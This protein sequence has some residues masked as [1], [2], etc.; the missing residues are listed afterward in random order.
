MSLANRVNLLRID[1]S[2]KI[3]DQL[4]WQAFGFHNWTQYFSFIDICV[5]ITE[6]RSSRFLVYKIPYRR[7][8]LA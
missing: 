6:S 3:V 2:S 4:P 7:A 8:R 5:R 1:S